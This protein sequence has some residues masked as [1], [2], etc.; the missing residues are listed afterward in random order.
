M[1]RHTHTAARRKPPPA[2]GCGDS[3]EPTGREPV[4]YEALTVG[5]G[6]IRIGDVVHVHGAE[7]SVRNMRKAAG[8]KVLIFDGGVVYPFGFHMSLDARRVYSPDPTPRTGPGAAGHGS[9]SH[10]HLP[11][12]ECATPG[13]HRAGKRIS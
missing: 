9:R 3:R 13:Q 7:R 5:E 12:H 11:P 10:P 8:G 6:T 1:P 4:V 2:Q